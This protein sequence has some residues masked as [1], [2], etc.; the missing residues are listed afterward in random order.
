MSS[1]SVVPMD[2]S[3]PTNSLSATYRGTCN[4]IDECLNYRRIDS[5]TAK[6]S[7]GRNSLP[8]Q[9]QETLLVLLKEI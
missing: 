6:K 4:E 3:A 7:R 9:T 8:L 5:M 2:R 1:F